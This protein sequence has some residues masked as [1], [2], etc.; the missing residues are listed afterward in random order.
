MRGRKTVR[1]L[2]HAAEHLYQ[3]KTVPPAGVVQVAFKRKQPAQNRNEGKK[4]QQQEQNAEPAVLSGT[5]QEA[6][7]CGQTQNRKMA[8][9]GR[10]RGCVPVIG[11]HDIA[12][13]GHEQYAD[14]F[15][16][17]R[18]GIGK[19]NL[20]T[21]ACPRQLEGGI[22]DGK[23]QEGAQAAAQSAFKQ[24]EKNPEGAAGILPVR[25]E[26]SAEE[27][28]AGKQR[29]G[30]HKVVIGERIDKAGK[31]QKAGPGSA[32]HGHFH[33]Q[34]DQR[35]KADDLGKVVKLRIDD[36]KGRKGVEDASQQGRTL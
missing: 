5:A 26:Q 7:R 34:Q 19:R 36:G 18:E 8:G 25:A 31:D 16:N 24:D 17:V 1:K 3:G 35:E 9:G 14:P 11:V 12:F 23:Q 20:C 13:N 2:A 22:Q 6:K 29:G 32:A 28:Q 27:I 4:E 15:Q 21:G 30:K 10:P 33:S